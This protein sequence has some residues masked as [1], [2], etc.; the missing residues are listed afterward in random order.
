MTGMSTDTNPATTAVWKEGAWSGYEDDNG[1][2]TDT[3]GTDA[4]ITMEV[5]SDF[6]PA[7]FT[8]EPG[9]ASAWFD[10]SHNGEGFILEMLADNRAVLYWFTFDKDGNQDW[11][12]GVGDVRGN[13]ILF[14]QLLRVSGGEFGP[15]FD[16]TMIT[17]ES[18]G[19]ATFI[20]SGCDSGSMDWHIGN[21]HSRQKLV[22]ITRIMG[23][24]CGAP[25]LA[26]LPEIA[27]LSGSWYDPSHAG[28]GFTV[29][30]MDDGRALV[31]WFSF[32]PNGERRW[33]FGVGEIIDGKMMIT[34]MITTRGGKF[35][36]D[37]NPATVEELPW[38]SLELA[39][40]CD[41]GTATYNS[42]EEGFGSGV[43]NVVRLSSM[44]GLACAP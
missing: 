2:E 14:T 6:L 32:G 4:T 37:F 21:E 41:G 43:L 28:E 12:I 20:W 30:V 27:L 15:G 36:P 44:A 19:S 11:Y 13:R 7:P 34:Q 25:Q 3:G 22:R 18:V 33:F 26:P 23:M 40:D 29:E 17:E 8:L 31:Y 24:E 39:I 38:G 10:P 16:P 9:I 1:L 35:G 42:S 5:T